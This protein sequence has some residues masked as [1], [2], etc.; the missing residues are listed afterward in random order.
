MPQ[1]P[2]TPDLVALMRQVFEAG[3]RADVDALMDFYAPDVILEVPD[4]GLTFDGPQ[5]VRGFYDDFFGLWEGF[6]SELEETLDLGHGVG[7]TV[8]R[9][10]GRPIGSS[11]EAQQRAAWVSAWVHRRIN[12][13]EIYV[14]VDLARS[15]AE[16]L[17]E[18]RG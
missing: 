2:Q 18:E 1:E 9:N 13:V 5:A 6:T 16:R 15:A 12:R 3:R 11:A 8:I 10:H 4:A 7:L 17:A 14:D